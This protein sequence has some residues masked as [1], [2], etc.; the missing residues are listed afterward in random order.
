MGM[1]AGGGAVIYSNP[2]LPQAANIVRAWSLRRCVPGYKRGNAIDERRTDGGTSTTQVFNKSGVVIMSG[3]DAYAHTLYD[4]MGNDASKLVSANFGASPKVFESGAMLKGLM[5]RLEDTSDLM[6]MA[7]PD[8]ALSAAL[9]DN[10]T[11]YTIS[12]WLKINSSSASQASIFSRNTQEAG[13]IRISHASANNTIYAGVRGNLSSELITMGNAVAGWNHVVVTLKGADGTANGRKA[14]LNVST[15]VQS[16]VP[17][18]P[19]GITAAT[20]RIGISGG[21]TEV[22]DII[23]W[24]RELSA[25]EVAALFEAQRVYYGVSAK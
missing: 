16:A 8:A 5:L 14:Y 23:V 17:T 1:G 2:V 6:A 18:I 24:N 10:I 19:A 20:A 7:A 9:N 15:V 11:G 4:Q 12:L 25:A 21:N 3:A 13:N 22:N